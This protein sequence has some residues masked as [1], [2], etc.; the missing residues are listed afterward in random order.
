[1]EEFLAFMEVAVKYV[2]GN[3]EELVYVCVLILLYMCPHT[4][5]FMQVAVKYVAGNSEEFVYVWVLILL[6]MCPHIYI[7][8]CGQVCGRKQ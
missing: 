8:S 4:A 3:G 6:Y 2:A 5:E 1:V 7:A